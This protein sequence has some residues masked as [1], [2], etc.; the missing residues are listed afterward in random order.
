M[1]VV[2]SGPEGG[3]CGSTVRNFKIYNY[4]DQEMKYMI[5]KNE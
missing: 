5:F 4:L 3:T 1:P 2:N